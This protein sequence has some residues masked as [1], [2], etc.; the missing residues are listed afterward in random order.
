MYDRITIFNDSA[1][2]V[3][4]KTIIWICRLTDCNLNK[5]SCEIVASTL[6]SASSNL[7]ELYLDGSAIPEAGL[8]A[9][10]DSVT[11]QSCMLEKL[12]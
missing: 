7:R 3:L 5:D 11:K 6:Q 10:C 8:K 4:V 12:R 9:L 2:T 1:N